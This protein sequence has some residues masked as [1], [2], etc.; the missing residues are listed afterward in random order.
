MASEDLRL[1]YENDRALLRDAMLKQK[2]VDSEKAI[3][4]A[5]IAAGNVVPL[6]KGAVLYKEGSLF[7]GVY[8]LLYGSIA[9]TRDDIQLT[10]LEPSNEVGTWPLL[11]PIPT[12]SVTATAVSDSVL[13]RVERAAF[14]EIADKYPGLWQRLAANQ[15]SQLDA[16][17]KDAKKWSAAEKKPGGTNAMKKFY[18]CRLSKF[19]PIRMQPIISCSSSASRCR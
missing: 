7:E 18:Q 2:L 5:L 6:P 1:S 4:D 9:L 16:M 15:A 8:F 3:A 12:Y 19:R 17:N 11:F 14:R 13:L 10:E